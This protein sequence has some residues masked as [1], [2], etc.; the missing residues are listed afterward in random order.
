MAGTYMALLSSASEKVTYSKDYST[1]L[2][3]RGLR[4]NYIMWPRF[5]YFDTVII[6]KFLF[7][8]YDISHRHT[9]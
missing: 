4:R 3:R 5:G 8:L 9:V 2:D 1:A 6:S 7:F